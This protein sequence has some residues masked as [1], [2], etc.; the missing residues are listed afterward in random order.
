[1]L[2]CQRQFQI[3]LPREWQ[4][5]KSSKSVCGWQSRS[6]FASSNFF[7]PYWR[8]ASETRCSV[9]NSARPEGRYRKIEGS[10]GDRGVFE[11]LCADHRVG[12]NFDRFR[13]GL[14]ASRKRTLAGSARTFSVLLCGSAMFACS[15]CGDQV[16]EEQLRVQLAE[17]DQSIDMLS[18]RFASESQSRFIQDFRV[19]MDQ[20]RLPCNLPLRF[21]P[22]SF[23]TS[24]R[25]RELLPLCQR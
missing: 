9:A 24:C 8:L 21:S 3:C 1:M 22:Y 12:P 13:T 4:N 19:L 23:L 16:E 5:P 15:V 20:V 11:N 17:I 6:V 14:R 7:A 18:Q 10:V 2:N 25:P